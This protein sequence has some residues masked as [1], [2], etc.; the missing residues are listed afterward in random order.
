MQISRRTIASSRPKWSVVWL[1]E[2]LKGM[3]ADIPVF[4][5]SFSADQH[6]EEKF[7]VKVF[8][9]WINKLPL[10]LFFRISLSL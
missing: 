7:F 9:M 10:R 5:Y 8:T 3:T 2:Q 1:L 6:T 4:L